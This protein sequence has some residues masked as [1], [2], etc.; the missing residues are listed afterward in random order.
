MGGLNA[1]YMQCC[2]G[3]TKNYNQISVKGVGEQTPYEMIGMRWF[4]DRDKPVARCFVG[5]SS[6]S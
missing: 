4:A 6:L 3:E 5:Q 1:G 2:M